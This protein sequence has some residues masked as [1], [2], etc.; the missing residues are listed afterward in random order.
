MSVLTVAAAKGSSSTRWCWSSRPTIVAESP[1]GVN[2]L[3]VALT[4]PTQ[5]LHVVH[6]RA[7]PPVWPD[8]LR[9]HSPS[10]E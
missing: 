5:R 4:R 3:Y 9:C 8:T 2:D 10:L 1:R 6:A 7:L